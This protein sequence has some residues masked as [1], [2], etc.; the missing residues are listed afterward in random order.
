MCLQHLRVCEAFKAK[1]GEV[2]AAP[3]KNNEMERLKA[4][5]ALMRQENALMKRGFEDRFAT[6]SHQ[7]GLGDPDAMSEGEL[8]ARA[9]RKIDDATQSNPFHGISE[10]TVKHFRICY[11][12]D[13]DKNKDWMT[14]EIATTH[15]KLMDQLLDSQK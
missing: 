4:E 3:D 9:K 13:N 14:P 15:K 2:A 1:G 11:H 10:P 6:I 7:L 8:V 12:P 5:M